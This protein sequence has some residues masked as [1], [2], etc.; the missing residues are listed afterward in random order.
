MSSSAMRGNTSIAASTAAN[1]LSSGAAS[2]CATANWSFRTPNRVFASPARLPCSTCCFDT[3]ARSQIAQVFGSSQVSMTSTFFRE[4]LVDVWV[5]ESKFESVMVFP[6]FS[7]RDCS[8]I[9]EFLTETSITSD[10]FFNAFCFAD[11]IRSARAALVSSDTPAAKKYSSVTDSGL[12]THAGLAPP[13]EHWAR[14]DKGYAHEPS[15]QIPAAIARIFIEDS[16][17]RWL[18]CSL[19]RTA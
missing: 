5:M 1:R 2:F 16:L 7:W 19:K 17:S 13:P 3:L 15:K 9:R 18:G 10:I 12:S 14:P 4:A 6:D 8:S 11:E